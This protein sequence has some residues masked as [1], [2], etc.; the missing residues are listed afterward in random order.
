MN[1]NSDIREGSNL[2]VVEIRKDVWTPFS[3]T[4][5]QSILSTRE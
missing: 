3:L 1:I 2:A 4:T 5:V